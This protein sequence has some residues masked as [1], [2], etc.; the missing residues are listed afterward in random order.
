VSTT[1]MEPDT[2]TGDG[3]TREDPTGWHPTRGEQDAE[4]SV[5]GAMLQPATATH[6]DGGQEQINS[7]AIGDVVMVLQPGHLF[8]PAH[9][10][11][12]QAIL[13][14]A[15]RG[16]SVDTVTVSGE[17]EHRGELSR[18]GGA[19]YLHHLVETLPSGANA[20]YYADMVREAA[21]RRAAIEYAQ[22]VQQAA[23]DRAH[24][25]PLDVAM[26]RAW[27]EYQHAIAGAENAGLGP[28][29]D[30]VD[31]LA[32]VLDQ[33]GTTSPSAFTTGLPDLDRV[34]NV[35]QGGLVVVGARSGVG[36]STLAARIARHYA[37]D[38]GEH[39][40]V[41]NMEMSRRELIQRDYAALAGVRQ[42]SADGRT[43]LDERQW[44]GL[45][46]AATRYQEQ[47]QR[48]HLDD[49]REVGLAHIRAR[50][51]QLHHQQQHDGG[52]GLVVV[53]QL[54]LMQLANRRDREDQEYT[55][56]TRQLKVLA[57]EYDCIVVLVAQL[58][59]GPEAR[60]DGKPRSS[61]LKSSGGT[62][63]DADV[64]MLIHDVGAWDE[65]RLGEI[66]VILDKQR[67]GIS[68]ATVSLADHRHKATFDSLD[69]SHS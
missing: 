62:E 13:D 15:G 32:A 17:L 37:F 22:R 61:D 64:V 9:T 2:F 59:R 7:P 47:G 38:R 65:N 42:D 57:G 69:T 12:Y 54:H 33:W 16:D 25:E 5:L 45:V 63:Q 3:D 49:T 53:D 41:I 23:A 1:S 19:L 44:N 50:M 36:K 43:N 46:R 66:D 51:Q 18:A 39:A 31:T 60:P 30:D 10:A 26:D 14:L 34:L 29:S 8:R 6:R 35:D 68:H 67:K 28:V 48:L 20:T 4:M 55:E 52:L 21:N 58:N 27:R 24:A 40:L 11:I 56:I